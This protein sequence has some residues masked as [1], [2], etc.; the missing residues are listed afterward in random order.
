MFS[1]PHFLFARV[2]LVEQPQLAK[3]DVAV[4]MVRATSGLDSRQQDGSVPGRKPKQRENIVMHWEY[5]PASIAETAPAEE[6]ASSSG[7]TTKK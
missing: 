5:H 1:P 2:D 6:A 7:P 4:G 3:G